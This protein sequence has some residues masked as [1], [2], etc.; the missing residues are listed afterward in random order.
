MNQDV[1]GDRK[2]FQREAGNTKDGKMENYS[3][4][5]HRMGNWQCEMK[6]LPGLGRNLLKLFI[7]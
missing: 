7:M 4:I 1:N 2:L 3:K 5:K 6:M